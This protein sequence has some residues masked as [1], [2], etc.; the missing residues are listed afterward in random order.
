MTLLS[1]LTE[2]WL[3]K[4]LSLIFAAVLWF[5]VMGEQRVER[6]YSFPLELRNVPKDLSVANEVPGQID[7][8]IS[9]PRTLL[10][11]LDEKQISI[12]INLDGLDAG[13]TT[14]RRLEERL[15]LPSGLKVTRVSPS[16]VEIQLDHI[17]RQS[18][19]VRVDIVGIPAQGFDVVSVR[20]DP[21]LVTVE[22]AERELRSLEAIY[23]EP[24]SVE[25]MKTDVKQTVP[26]AYDGSFSRLTEEKV[27]I[28]VDIE[29]VQTPDETRDRSKM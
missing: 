9:G 4:V 21:A 17:R 16:Y 27:D 15:N 3:L 19:P 22:G 8:R 25:G 7:V 20:I 29:P 5:F 13:T 18:F 6:S 24:L 23:T 2:N 10:V 26:L 1:K 28:L 12:P 11:N 14:F